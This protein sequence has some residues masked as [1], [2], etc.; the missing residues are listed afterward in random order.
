MSM[1]IVDDLHDLMIEN[2][3]LKKEID[4]LRQ[5]MHFA[6]VKLKSFKPDLEVCMECLNPDS[7]K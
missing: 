3:R 2:K 4:Y 7:H 6:L 5:E 1:E